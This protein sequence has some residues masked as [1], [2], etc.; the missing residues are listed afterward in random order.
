MS[1][2]RGTGDGAREERPPVKASDP[3][4]QVPDDQLD[5]RRTLNG[6]QE[7]LV[8]SMLMLDRHTVEE[9]L[10]VL[11][12]SVESVTGCVLVLVL[13]RLHGDWT[14][15]P[16]TAVEP[17]PRDPGSLPS[18]VPDGD[19]WTCTTA[20]AALAGPPGQLVLRSATEPGPGQLFLIERLGHLLGTAL[21]DAE[22]HERDRRR[23]IELD[24][25][26]EELAATVA[27]LRHRGAGAGVVLA[28][29]G[30]RSR[31]GRGG[32]AQPADG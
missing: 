28:A 8:L 30:H 22:L 17:E 18:L 1:E 24:K 5:L 10:Q 12:S 25:V 6:V 15:W 29:R 13:F 32:V 16:P 23:T 14:T 20:V 11:A 9:V 3:N 2:P 21:A 4:L 7:L 27:S 31:S 26:N 19:S